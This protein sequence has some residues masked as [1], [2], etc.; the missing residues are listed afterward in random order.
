[1]LHLQ[2]SCISPVLQIFG[3]WLNGIRNNVTKDL[4]IVLIKCIILY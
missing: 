3:D 1:M 2:Y 4:D